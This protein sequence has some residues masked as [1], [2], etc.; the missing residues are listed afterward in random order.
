M[1]IVI[2]VNLHMIDDSNHASKGV[3]DSV[4]HFQEFGLVFE[5]DAQ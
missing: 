3:G 5:E 1:M 2:V 4:A